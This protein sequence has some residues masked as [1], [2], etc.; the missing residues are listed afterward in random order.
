MSWAA[1]FIFGIALFHSKKE[2]KEGRFSVLTHST[3]LVK[4]ASMKNLN[5]L[6]LIA[7]LSSS[8]AFCAASIDCGKPNHLE[9]GAIANPELSI[10][11]ET[12]NFSGPAGKNWLL[13]M[14][15]AERK[16]TSK[17]PVSA[18][19]VKNADGSKSVIIQIQDAKSVTGPVGTQIRIQKLYTDK[20]VAEFTVMGGFAGGMREMSK[21]L[22]CVGS[23][24]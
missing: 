8:S 2:I 23:Y 17:A 15:G 3:R 7:L 21:D 6:T 11:S 1:V 24:D 16:S 18:K 19:M 20:T 14:A 10:S 12:D 13:F 9:D 4:S 22:V 5:L